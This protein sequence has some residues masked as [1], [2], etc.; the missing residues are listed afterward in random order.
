MKYAYPRFKISLVVLSSIAPKLK[1]PDRSRRRKK[2]GN[3]ESALTPA[4]PPAKTRAARSPRSHT[5][6][7]SD[8]TCTTAANAAKRPLGKTLPTPRPCA[9]SRGTGQ[10]GLGEQIPKLPQAIREPGTR[11]LRIRQ[12]NQIVP[13][14]KAGFQG[15][16]RLPAKPSGAV[17]P[18][19][20]RKPLGKGKADTVTGQAVLQHEKF[21]PPAS[22]APALVK[23]PPDFAPFF[24]ALVPPKAK[25]AFYPR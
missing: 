2:G 13:M 11:I 7:K 18:Y 23:N 22:D 12:K 24:Q 8:S 15:A 3:A 5:P 17:P 1:G 19:R 21:R 14:V 9:S 20:A 25:R 16:V 6:N 10:T 4:E